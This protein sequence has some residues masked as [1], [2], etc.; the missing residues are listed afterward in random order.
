MV[1]G[2]RIIQVAFH[3]DGSLRDIYILGTSEHDWRALLKFLRASRYPLEF[4]DGRD[5]QSPPAQVANM[6]A[7]MKEHTTLYIDR[8]RLGLNCHFF[9]ME[10]IEF[11]LDPKDFQNEE[12]VSRLLDFI[13][14]VGQALHKEVALT[15]ENDAQHPL[16]RYDPA[17]NEETWFLEGFRG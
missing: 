12:Q 10:E 8:E 16:F 15:A 13:R 5:F 2:S 4:G 11:D 6:F 9:T 3:I 1:K 14:T 17:T 7:L